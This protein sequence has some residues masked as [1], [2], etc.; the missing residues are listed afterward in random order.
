M[1]ETELDR[2]E[3]ADAARFRWLVA[4]NSYLLEEF[5]V[6]DCKGE[7][8]EDDCRRLIDE[9]MEE[10][11][12]R[13]GQGSEPPRVVTIDPAPPRALSEEERQEIR[14]QAAALGVPPPDIAIG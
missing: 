11:P 12:F 2:S 10:H 8:D 9:W 1:A 14:E 4:G 13:C 3:A 5:S 7:E 6:G